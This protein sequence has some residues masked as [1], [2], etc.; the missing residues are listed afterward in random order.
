MYPATL[1]YLNIPHSFLCFGVLPPYVPMRK[2]DVWGV[3]MFQFLTMHGVFFP[4]TREPPV[5][6]LEPEQRCISGGV[7]SALGFGTAIPYYVHG[8]LTLVMSAFRRQTYVKKV[9]NRR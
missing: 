7:K 2:L 6:G 1:P 5:P 8:G 3:A 4:S 9:K